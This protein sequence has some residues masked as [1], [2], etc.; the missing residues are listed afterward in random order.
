[1]M[2]LLFYVQTWTVLLMKTLRR[3]PFGRG[4]CTDFHHPFLYSFYSL[5]KINEDKGT[6]LSIDQAFYGVGFLIKFSGLLFFAQVSSISDTFY[7]CVIS[8]LHGRTCSFLLYPVN[9]L[10]YHKMFIT[11]FRRL[12]KYQSMFILCKNIMCHNFCT[13]WTYREFKC[14][15]IWSLVLKNFYVHKILS[16][17]TIRRQWG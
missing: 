11:L 1:M 17:T 13:I 2:D 12:N 3:N 14:K 10:K 15:F 4:Y 5:V 9:H 7:V 6:F 16:K 8:S